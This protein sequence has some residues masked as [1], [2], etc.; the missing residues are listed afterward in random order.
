MVIVG[1]GASGL[2]CAVTAA[3]LGV[4]TTVLERTSRCG[5]KLAVT[6]GSRCN[7]THADTAR[8]MA[9]KFDCKPGLLMPL[10]R[11][12]TY[13]RI[14]EF[15]ASIGVTCQADHQGCI[16][17]RKLGARQLR[18]MLVQ[19]A[20]ASGVDIRTGCRVHRVSREAELWHVG[21]ERGHHGAHAVC[22]ATG[23]ASYAGTGSSGDGL[24]LSSALGLATAGWFPALCSLEPRQPVGEL[25]GITHRS[26]AMTLSVDG[27]PVRKA[28]GRFIFAHRYVSGSEVL[29]LSG[30]A[31][32]ALQQGQK[33][34]LA[35]DWAPSLGRD[36]LAERI[37]LGRERNGRRLAASW[38]TVFVAR[39]LAN[40]LVADAGVPA[41]R[42]MAQLTEADL[43]ALVR[44]LKTTVFDIVGT[45]PIE[46]ATVTGGGVSLNEVDISTCEVRR[47]PRLH[48]AGELLDTWAETGG[49]NLHFAWATGIAAGEAVARNLTSDRNL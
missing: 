12:F 25:A 38:L 8:H 19:A 30:H 33:V 41:D 29:N 3:R 4:S 27:R 28:A 26:A 1:G 9:A 24:A 20:L 40:R 14:A 48:I 13:R 35:V 46:R 15:F 7:L 42:R 10:F 22:I 45:E 23:G 47:L 6:G 44:V 2:S 37:S 21:T 34:R 11:K 49:Y 18:D 5:S 32:R 31:A 43:E 36:G 17:P 39:R 16:W